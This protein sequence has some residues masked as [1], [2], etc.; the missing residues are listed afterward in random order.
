MLAC[1]AGGPGSIPGRCKVFLFFRKLAFYLCVS[2]NM[3]AINVHKQMILY[4]KV[5]IEFALHN[6]MQFYAQQVIKRCMGASKSY[7]EMDFLSRFFG[8]SLFVHYAM[9]QCC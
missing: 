9:L 1:H 3:A 7:G 2:R 6:E 5:R 4:P 8:C